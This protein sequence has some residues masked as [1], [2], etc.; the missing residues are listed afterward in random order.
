MAG[1]LPQ[2]KVKEA[3][4][5]LHDVFVW[6]GL[7]IT[8][9]RTIPIDKY[10]YMYGTH[11]ENF[12]KDDRKYRDAAITICGCIRNRQVETQRF[13]AFDNAI[14][15][16]SQCSFLPD[17]SATRGYVRETPAVLCSFIAWFCTENKLVY[18]NKNT[19]VEEMKQI[20]STLI[21]SVLWDNYLYAVGNTP[22]NDPNKSA[23]IASGPAEVEAPAPAPTAPTGTAQSTSVKTGGAAGHT[24]F[25]K[26]AGGILTGG[27]LT[28][29]SN[30]KYVYWIGGVFVNA[31]K[32]QPKLHVKP[33]GAKS[34][35]KVDYGSG[36]GYN[37]CILYFASEGAAKN[38]LGIADASKPSKIKSL[39]VKKIGEDPNGYV[40]VD[41]EFGHAY[42]KASKLHEE[43]E[44][45][46]QEENNTQKVSNKE[47]WE[48]YKE[49]FFSE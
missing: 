29:I 47:V 10:R 40:E 6:G 14:S 27:K 3:K 21:G 4:A 25:R 48:A 16:L 2:D 11:D 33:Q 32:T 49:G 8:P 42:I 44:E 5:W 7:A 19:S 18:N 36:Q 35:L 45:C 30:N 23:S 41:T 13:L 24:L 20:R 28:G 22:E 15:V 46:I 12:R 17:L 31:G 39:Q 38:F 43:V 26:N 1:I 37:D 9:K 34:P